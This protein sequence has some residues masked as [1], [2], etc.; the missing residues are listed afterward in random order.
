MIDPENRRFGEGFAERSVELLRGRK[1]A[2]KRLF[3]DH[4]CSLV[5]ARFG[6]SFRYSRKRAW[7]D[8]QV[9]NRSRCLAERFS[10]IAEGR[11]RIVVSFDVLEFCRKH[12]ERPDV[13]AAVLLTTLASMGSELVEVFRG[14]PHSDNRDVEVSVPDHCLECREDLLRRQ[15]ASG[16]KEHKRI[17]FEIRHFQPPLLAPVSQLFQVPAESPVIFQNLPQRM[18][19]RGQKRLI[20]E[21]RAASGFR[22]EM[23]TVVD[24]FDPGNR[25]FPIFRCARQRHAAAF[26]PLCREMRN[27]FILKRLIRR[28][29]RSPWFSPRV[30]SRPS[31]V[32]EGL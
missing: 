28:I 5:T 17:R 1:V 16:A 3:N 30:K 14:P 21:I 12:R 25:F 6:K 2:A 32:L 24:T 11:L 31:R 29:R 8:G 18:S 7:R 4:S 10:Q 13:H 9:I 19:K 26:R 15:I 22:R 27:V 20:G 23:L